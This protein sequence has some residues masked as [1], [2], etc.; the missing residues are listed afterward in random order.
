MLP[1]I[2]VPTIDITIPSTKAKIKFTRF[3]VRD[4]KILLLAKES[5]DQRDILNAIKQVIANCCQDV[6][7]DVEKLSITDCEY[8][9]LKLH[10]ASVLNIAKITVYDPEDE[11]RYPFDIDLNTVEVDDSKRKDGNVTLSENLAVHLNYPPASLYGDKAFSESKD[12]IFDTVLRCMDKIYQGD[13]VF[14]TKNET[15]EELS[16]WISSLDYQSYGKIKEFY[17]N[18]P[19]LYYEI[20][21]KNSLGTERVYTL[22]TLSDFFTL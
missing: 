2:N 6:T 11:K 4:E 21:Y 15:K 8:V 17:E 7:I 14:E 10:A 1:K 20:K 16:K 9:F 13:T 12:P 18:A 3:L 22:R 5:G 19:A